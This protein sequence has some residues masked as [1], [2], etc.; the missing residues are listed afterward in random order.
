MR[1]FIIIFVFI[2]QIANS[3]HVIAQTGYTRVTNIKTPNNSTVQDTYVFTGTDLSYTS[4][5][6]ET[7]IVDLRANYGGAELL[8]IPTKT[9]NSHGYAWHMSEGGSRVW[10][11][12]PGSTTTA[13]NIYWT[14]R[15]YIEVEESQATK[16]SYYGDHSAVRVDNTW[17]ISKWGEYCLVKHKPNFVLSSY[18]PTM[19]KKFYSSTYIT[20]PSIVCGSAGDIFTVVSRSL[21]ITPSWTCS[22]NILYVSSTGKSAT[23]KVNGTST[24]PGWIKATVNGVE[25]VKNVSTGAIPETFNITGPG[26]IEQYHSGEYFLTNNYAGH[27]SITP[28]G[29]FYPNGYGSSQWITCDYTGN[30]KITVVVYN[31][32]GCSLSK[33]KNIGV[34]PEQDYNYA[35]AYPNPTSNTL[36]ID[37]DPVSYMQAKS[38]L[39][40]PSTKTAKTINT[41]PDFDIRLYDGQGNIVR[42]TQSKGGSVQFNVSNLSTGIFYLHIYDGISKK[43]HIQQVVVEH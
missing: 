27:W 39:L 24:S 8:D 6:I 34:Y 41:V 42:R 26:T 12:Y 9:Y 38:S 2:F 5:Q 32:S 20:G 1:F 33:S 4:T 35:P 25:Y 43:P 13:E 31:M 40:Q 23:F 15:S 36:N 18:Q 19:P 30:H 10:I 17:Y 11:G 21:N 16:V 3:L 14:D 22:S 7:M 37:I 28:E 29:Y